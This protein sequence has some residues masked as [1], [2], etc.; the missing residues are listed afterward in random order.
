M[1]TLS[2]PLNNFGQTDS[3][4]G[5]YLTVSLGFSPIITLFS[6]NTFCYKS[7]LDIGDTPETFGIISIVKDTV[8]FE[9]TQQIHPEITHSTSQ[10][11][12]EIKKIRI[13]VSGNFDLFQHI[14]L[15]INDPTSDNS[16][17]VIF[18]TNRTVLIDSLNETDSLFIYINMYSYIPIIVDHQNYNDFEF[19]IQLPNTYTAYYLTEKKALFKNGLLYFF[20]NKNNPIYY[21]TNIYYKKKE[22]KQIREFIFD[23]WIKNL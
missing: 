23:Q 4:Y 20:E 10:H 1:F 7:N 19:Q 21:N 8:Y 16:K 17:R 13:H 15:F 2:L 11:N 9:Y 14:S 6:N 3:I 5:T 22:E 18:D 12:P